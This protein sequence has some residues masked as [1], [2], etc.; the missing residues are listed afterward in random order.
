MNEGVS[1]R[2]H[3]SDRN[4]MKCNLFRSLVYCTTDSL[5]MNDILTFGYLVLL[6]LTIFTILR[7]SLLRQSYILD[8][9]ATLLYRLRVSLPRAP[10][11]STQSTN[12]DCLDFVPSNV[13]PAFGCWALFFECVSS[14]MGSTRELQSCQQQYSTRSI[15]TCR[16]PEDILRITQYSQPRCC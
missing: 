11:R 14:S 5:T 10:H 6:H 9:Q 12:K 1:L 3:C 13:K 8:S 4:G 16:R 2:I 7:N 15:L